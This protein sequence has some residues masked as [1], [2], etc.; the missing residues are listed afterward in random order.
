MLTCVCLTNFTRSDMYAFHEMP[1][2]S[3]KAG[4][5]ADAALAASVFDTIDLNRNGKISWEELWAAARPE[6]EDVLQALREQGLTI[7]RLLR[8]NDSSGDGTLSFSEFQKLLMG[9]GMEID[10][11]TAAEVFKRLDA[12]GDQQLSLKTLMGKGRPGVPVKAVISQLRSLR[13]LRRI[14]LGDLK[15]VCDANG[16][17]KLTKEH[18]LQILLKVAWH[19]LLQ[20]FLLE[21]WFEMLD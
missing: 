8:E 4:I 17:A 7:E 21:N 5:Q 19:C 14:S 11:E 9:L 6:V 15:S 10:Q 18:F 1:P 12:D 20:L 3:R 16:D 13:L 2:Q